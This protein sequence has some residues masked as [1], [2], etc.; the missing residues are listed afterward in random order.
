MIESESKILISGGSQGIGRAIGRHF[1]ERGHKIFLLDIDKEGL[2]H[3][4]EVHLKQYP[5][6]VAWSECDLSD[7]EAIRTTVKKAADYF[8]GRIDFLINNA[9]ISYPYW[10][11]GKTMEDPST[12]DI[13]RKYLDVNLTGNFALSQAAIPYMKVEHD[14]DKQKMPESKV[15]TA[16]PCILNISSFRGQISDPNQE[17]Y[18]ASKGR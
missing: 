10:P 12:L 18:A 6:L 7:I 5:D 14:K 16:G 13:W 15:G 11:D 1:A 17:G 3:T 2:K 9:G 4:A 8:G